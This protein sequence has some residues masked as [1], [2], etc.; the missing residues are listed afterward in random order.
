[1]PRTPPVTRARWFW[2]I[3][4]LLLL[5]PTGLRIVHTARP[6][7]VPPFVNPGYFDL[8]IFLDQV[9]T[10]DQTG[11]LY[12]TGNPDFF[13]PGSAVYKYPPTFAALL[14]PFAALRWRVAVRTLL[15]INFAI[16]LVGLAGLLAVL[17]PGWRRGLLL[18]LVFLHWGAFWES[19]AGMQLEPLLLLLLIGSLGCLRGGRHFWAG[20]AVGVAAALKVYPAGLIA[21]FALRRRWTAVAGM[22]AGGAAALGAASV[23]LSMRPTVEYLTRILPKLGGTSLGWDNISW[24]GSL[25][26][27]LVLGFAGPARLQ[28]LTRAVP[29]GMLETGAVGGVH[30]T[31]IILAGSTA[32]LLVF[33]TARALRRPP[34]IGAA[35]AP[36]AR[37]SLGYGA[38]LCLLLF[39]M[40][41]SWPDYQTLLILPLAIAIAAAPDPRRD[42]LSWLLIAAAAVAGASTVHGEVFTQHPFLA[43]VLRGWIPLAIWWAIVRRRGKL[44]PG[45]AASAASAPESGP[46]PAGA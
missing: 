35:L 31:T 5:V 26:R 9:R 24:V 39:L 25:G 1:M 33:L 27:L 30:A 16:L 41:T 38:A 4:F 29:R 23:A 12:A 28:E 43:T 17:R 40:P 20:F 46:L 45:A 34:A 7:V 13:D 22:A 2:V 44:T 42:A 8:R 36:A 14:H 21:Y 3:L 15:V 37:E 19:L 18:A 6:Y 10:Y 32:A 11:E